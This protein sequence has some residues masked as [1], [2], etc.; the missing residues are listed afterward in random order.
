[1]SDVTLPRKPLND[2]RSRKDLYYNVIQALMGV[3]LSDRCACSTLSDKDLLYN[4][5]LAADGT[6]TT[7]SQVHRICGCTT[8]SERD[9]LYDFVIAMEGRTPA[10]DS[11]YLRP[12]GVDRY[13]R[14]GGVFIFLRP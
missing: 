6:V 13:F 11:T 10:T 2:T 1:M 14:P 12:G 3:P 8:L 9:L 4:M 5:V 7:M